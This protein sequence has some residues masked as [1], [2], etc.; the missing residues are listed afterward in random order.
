MC[1]PLPNGLVIL[2]VL[3][4]VLA[5]VFDCECSSFSCRTSLLLVLLTL[6]LVLVTL[7][8]ELFSIM[9]PEVVGARL[10]ACHACTYACCCGFRPHWGCSL[11]NDRVVL[12]ALELLALLALG[13]L[14]WSCS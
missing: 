2:L 14:R 1:L 10:V 12:L 11:G 4:M 8:L 6:V 7:A 3:V 5:F 9:L 13:Y